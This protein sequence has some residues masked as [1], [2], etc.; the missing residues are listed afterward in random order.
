MKAIDKMKKK[1]ST[2]RIALEN[3][4]QNFKLQRKNNKFLTGYPCVWMLVCIEALM[5]D[6]LKSMCTYVSIPTIMMEIMRSYE[7]KPYCN[8]KAVFERL[9]VK[10]S[11]VYYTTHVLILATNTKS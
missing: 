4:V 10:Y 6:I 2:L 5:D 9:M 8:I 7:K 1:V 3:A 11:Y